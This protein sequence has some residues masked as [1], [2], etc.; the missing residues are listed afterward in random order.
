MKLSKKGSIFLEDKFRIQLIARAINK[1]GSMRQLG[2]VMGYS[3]NSP[4]WSIKQILQ[5]NQGIPLFR[6]ERLCK[7]MRISFADIEKNVKK[8]M[9]AC[10]R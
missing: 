6:L 7:F 4:N 1:A 3:A 10:K 9:H 2:R 8:C 5:G